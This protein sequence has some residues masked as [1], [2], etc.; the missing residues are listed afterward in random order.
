MGPL[1]DKPNVA[2]VDR[3]VEEAIAAGAK[4]VV[5]G[6]P[7]TD[8]E[9]ARGAF[10]RP[11][12]LEVDSARLDIVQ[13]E[14]FGPVMTMQVFDT[15]AEAVALAN[16]SEYGPRQ[17]GHATQRSMRVA[18]SLQAGTIWINDWAKVYDEFEEGG[19]RQSG[20]GR[21]NGAAAI[22]DFIEYK[23]ITLATGDAPESQDRTGRAPVHC[24]QQQ[25][26]GRV[27]RSRA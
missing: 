4:V 26:V 23:H 9:L 11:T 21:L 19:Y 13:K 8:G 22:D 20:L 2:R 27:R 24:T 15:E 5:R 17:S 10:Y 25:H 3:A 14:T 16:D 7:V 18:R 12:L 6:G 1:I